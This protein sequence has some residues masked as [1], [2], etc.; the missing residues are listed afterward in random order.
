[1]PELLWPLRIGLVT[2]ALVFTPAEVGDDRLSRAALCASETED[3]E[4]EPEPGSYCL[5][6]GAYV[7]DV[8]PSDS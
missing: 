3:D 4:C 7:L 5:V 8:T 2:L 6:D 1:M